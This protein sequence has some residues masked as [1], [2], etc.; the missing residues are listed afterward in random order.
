MDKHRQPVHQLPNGTCHNPRLIQLRQQTVTL[1]L[2]RT[3][4]SVEPVIGAG[5]RGLSDKLTRFVFEKFGVV[6]G[7]RPLLR[8]KLKQYFHLSAAQCRI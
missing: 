7:K 3:D 1:P 8:E 2:I 5:I 4:D 6:H